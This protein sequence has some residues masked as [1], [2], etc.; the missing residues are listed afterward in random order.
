MPWPRKME[1][2]SLTSEEFF[3]TLSWGSMTIRLGLPNVSTVNGE[4]VPCTSIRFSSVL[5]S[6]SIFNSTGM[7]NKSR[8]CV[9]LPHHPKALVVAEAVNRVLG[10]ELGRS[11]G[12]EPLCEEPLQ[13]VSVIL[14]RDVA[15][16]I[17]RWRSVPHTWWRRR[18]WWH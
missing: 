14:L 1:A 4:L 13:L 5:P 9:I 6:V 3:S 8:S 18:A 15:E 12:I 17:E 7:R 16:V 10:L 11:R 2:R